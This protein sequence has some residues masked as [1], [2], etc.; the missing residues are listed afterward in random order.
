MQDLCKEYLGFFLWLFVQ[1]CKLSEEEQ[2]AALGQAFLMTII[3]CSQPELHCVGEGAEV[4]AWALCAV[5][6]SVQLQL[7][8][9][10]C[11]LLGI[12]ELF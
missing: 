3:P 1:L 6:A 4:T 10:N 2:E 9:S 8:S 12:F 5:A 11:T 7:S